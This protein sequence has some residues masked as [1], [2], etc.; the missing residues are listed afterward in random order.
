QIWVVDR[1]DAVVE[2]VAVL[3]GQ[4]PDELHAIPVDARAQR[5]V[6]AVRDEQDPGGHGVHVSID[7]WFRPRLSSMPGVWGRVRRTAGSAPT[8]AICSSLS[9]TFPGSRCGSWPRP[10]PTCPA[11][12]PCCR[13]SGVRAAA[14]SPSSTSCA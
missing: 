9:V 13:C 5:V 8:Y 2:L 10:A 11:A 14:S 4:G 12:S 7:A 6:Q 1:A 3:G